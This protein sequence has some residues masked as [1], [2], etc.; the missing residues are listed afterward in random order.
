MKMFKKDFEIYF[1]FDICYLAFFV[2]GRAKNRNFVSRIHDVF[3]N[4]LKCPYVIFRKDL[5]KFDS[6]VRKH[7]MHYT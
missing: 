5:V 7:F 4:L 3:A 2:V 1:V 6:L